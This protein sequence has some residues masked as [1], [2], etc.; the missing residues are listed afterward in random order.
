MEGG[1]GDGREGTDGE[2]DRGMNGEMDGYRLLKSKARLRTHTLTKDK[3]S[4]PPGFF[5]RGEQGGEGLP[6]LD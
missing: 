6:S 1:Q 5:D 3:D 4:P 2:T